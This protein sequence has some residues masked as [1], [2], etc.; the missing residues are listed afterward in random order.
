MI[1]LLIK[2][3]KDINKD[4]FEIIEIVASGDQNLNDPLYKMQSIGVFTKQVEK[5]LL[6]GK[7]DIAVHSLKDLPTIQ[8]EQLSINAIPRLQNR[9]DTIILHP[10]HKGI[11]GLH[12]L[13]TNS[14]IGSSSL[15]RIQCLKHHYP[16]LQFKD[17]RGNL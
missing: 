17:I 4:D 10:K 13:P 9:G 15:R 16:N 8:H 11:E 14:I 7:G 6:N 12:E 5:E 1:D 3:N 2:N